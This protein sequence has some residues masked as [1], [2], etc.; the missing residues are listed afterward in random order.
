MRLVSR[1][2]VLSGIALVAAVAL[3]LVVVR[4]DV[5]DQARHRAV[6]DAQRVAEQ[7]TADSSSVAAFQYWG[8]GGKAAGDRLGF[9][10]DFFT[11]AGARAV[12]YSPGA[13]VTYAA[14]RQLI[15]TTAPRPALVRRA[16]T[17]PQYDVSGGIESAYVPVQSAFKSHT[18]LGVLRV[19]H[20]YGP[21]AAAIRHDFATQAVTVGAALALLY[22][23]MLP[24]MRRVTRSLRRAYVERAELAAIVDHSNDAIVAHEPGGAIT[25]WNAGAERIYGWRA[26]EV[27]GRDIEL[28]LPPTRIDEPGEL[29]LSRT[30]HV[31]KD[32]TPVQVSV[33]VSP[34][35]DENG[36]IVGSSLTARDVTQLA[37]LE[38]EL[39]ELHRQEAVARLAGE[40]ARDFDHILREVDV[41]VARADEAAIARATARGEAIVKQLLEIGSTHETN[42]ELLDLNEAVEATIGD[43][44]DLAGPWVNVGVALEPNLGQVVAD[45][46]QVRELILNLAANARATMHSGG[47]LELRTAN[48]DFS[49]RRRD[50]RRADG[51]YVMIAVSDSEPAVVSDDGGRMALGLAAACAIVK[52]NG[53]T[54]GTETSPEGG[55]VIRVYLPRADAQDRVPLPA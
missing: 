28:L 30:T 38:R 4:A 40:V 6:A 41:A 15:G 51:R 35:R 44:R 12:L 39:Q 50:G 47:R 9:V 26:D 29:D 19:E 25:S 10:D 45:P 13:L 27:L 11:H 1:F 16:L 54:L 7:F 17:K 36:V 53:G 43:I 49:R 46:T 42:P 18:V 33:T 2:A 22:L 48:V 20:D 55:T 52:Q 5:R 21:T 23:A 37:E 34:I 32:G 31:R 3:T 24:L 8:P 14:D